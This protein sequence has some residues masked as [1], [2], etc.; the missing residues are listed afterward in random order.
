MARGKVTP[1]T[2]EIPVY[3]FAIVKFH[4][5]GVAQF[6]V[7]PLKWIQKTGNKTKIYWPGEDDAATPKALVNLIMKEAVID[8]ETWMLYNITVVAKFDTYAGAQKKLDSAIAGEVVVSTDLDN[9]GRGGRNKAKKRNAYAASAL[10]PTS[11]KK[12]VRAAT[13]CS[14]EEEDSESS[15]HMGSVEL[16][17][18]SSSENDIRRN[19]AKERNAYAASALTP[20]SNK[21]RVRASCSDGE[22]DSERSSHMCSVE[23]APSSSSYNDI[24]Q[25]KSKVTGKKQVPPTSSNGK[26]VT[27][28]QPQLQL[29]TIPSGLGKKQANSEISLSTS[30]TKSAPPPRGSVDNTEGGAKTVGTEVVPL[31]YAKKSTLPDYGP[32]AMD[33]IGNDGISSANKSSTSMEFGIYR[34]RSTTVRTTEASQISTFVS[35]S[36]KIDFL[37]EQNKRIL[38][39]QEQIKAQN[40]DIKNT[41]A[42]VMDSTIPR[43][44]D[45][46]GIKEEFHIPVTDLKFFDTLNAVLKQDKIK[47]SKMRTYLIGVGGSQSRVVG[48]MLSKL[49]KF[50]VGAQFCLKGQ[51]ANKRRFDKTEIMDLVTECVRSTPG[52][53]LTETDVKTKIGR[54]LKSAPTKL[55]KDDTEDE[56]AESGENDY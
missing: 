15:S 34:Q 42:V 17:P 45:L 27:A 11:S 39:G 4:H 52:V 18:S 51:N 16:A 3:S 56:S 49:M 14:D 9:R 13:S 7:A 44:P 26:A 53:R 20:T 23:L 6:D 8:K 48:N 28:K 40:L 30:K 10:P 32:L 1:Q 29:P 12:R 21:K 2:A 24:P 25:D 36:K 54:W 31:I 55:G 35:D 5:V 22:E 43:E 46:D 38:R 47:K 50:S 37:I 19:K 41:L 33:G